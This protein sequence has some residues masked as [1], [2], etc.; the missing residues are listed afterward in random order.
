MASS[1]M[2]GGGGRV[3]VSEWRMVGS[4]DDDDMAMEGDEAYSLYFLE[5]K[6]WR[7]PKRDGLVKT[8]DGLLYV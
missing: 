6:N 3:R 7:S 8:R 2:N 4:G 1:A 5:H